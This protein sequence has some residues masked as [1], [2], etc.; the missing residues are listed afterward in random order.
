MQA[1]SSSLVSAM[2]FPASIAAFRSMG[3]G[4]ESGSLSV[5][6]DSAWGSAGGRAA[7]SGWASEVGTGSKGAATWGGGE[8]NKDSRRTSRMFLILSR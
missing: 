4:R 8:L 6:A 5:G 1:M 7:G 3:I 2:R